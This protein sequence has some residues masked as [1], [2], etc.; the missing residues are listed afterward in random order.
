MKLLFLAD[1]SIRDVIG[2]AERVLFEQTT[3]LAEKGHSV[4]LL[5]RK[6][7]EHTEFRETLHGVQEERCPFDARTPAR[8]FSETWPNVCRQFNQLHQRVGFDCINIHQPTTAY[9]AL[10][11]AQRQNVPMVYTCHSLSFEEYFSRNPPGA[12]WRRP[13]RW[14]NAMARRVIEKSVLENCC[15]VIALS[16]YTV[17]KLQRTYGVPRDRIE[18]IPAGVDLKKFC[19][20]VDKND[21]R[22][23][24]EV[25]LGSFLLLTVRNLEPRMGLDRL[26]EAMKTVVQRI[27]DAY[28]IIGGEGPLEEDLRAQTA[29]SSLDNHVRFTGFILEK[30]L[31]A[32]Y[33]LADLFVL[34]SQDLE[35]F[36][37]VTL[38]ALACGLPVIGT[39]VGGTIEILSN[40]DKRFLMKGCSAH[41]IAESI[42]LYY[43]RIAES[44]TKALQVAV[45]CRTYIEAH[46]GWDQNIIALEKLYEKAILHFLPG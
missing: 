9:G 45:D 4:Y 16:D 17:D 10:K 36:G 30:D 23:R 7:P 32:Y 22:R 31:P 34:P 28:L 6:I 25:P 43:N 35:G 2:G 41:Q 24:Y 19:P 13:I 39:P 38:E 15:R 3:R 1:V 5:T 27:P 14:I 42:I 26:I 21:L 37:M 46:Y 44:R 8:L 11:A 40:L 12:L 29:G 20:A 33:Q 18:V